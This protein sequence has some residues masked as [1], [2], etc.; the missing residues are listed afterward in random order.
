MTYKGHIQNGVVVLDEPTL[1]PEGAEVRIDLVEDFSS[2]PQTS[3]RSLYEELK[4]LIGIAQ[5]LPRDMAE[6]HD[7][8]LHGL[9][10]R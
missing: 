5:G 3:E 9:P 10:K 7:H 6:N 8:Y 2:Q 1:L 4:D